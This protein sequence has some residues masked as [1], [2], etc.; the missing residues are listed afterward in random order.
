[1]S[2]EGA[3][4]GYAAG[5]AL[6]MAG[7]ASEPA[8]VIRN[9]TAVALAG[10]GTLETGVGLD[11]AEKAAFERIAATDPRFGKRLSEPP[12]A[13]QLRATAVKALAEG[14]PDVSVRD[15]E[16]DF[17]SFTA[18]A[19]ALDEAAKALDR[20]PVA[21]AAAGEDAGAA[22]VRLERELAAR[23]IREERARLDEERSLPRGASALVRG[24]EETW[25]AP[26]SPQAA[27][28]RDAWLT[29]RLDEIRDSLS[30]STLA[31][32][33]LLELD[34][35]LDPLERIAPPDVLPGAA[36]AIARL[37]VSL[38]AT[39]SGGTGGDDTRRARL[40]T[41]VRAHLGLPFEPK[42]IRARL[43][44]AERVTRALA[45]SAVTEA[46]ER[47]VAARAEEVTLAT[48][49]CEAGLFESRVRSMAPPPERGAICGLLRAI[50]DN[51]DGAAKAAALVALHDAAVVGLWALA[52][53]ADGALPD[54]AIASA[55]PFFGAQPDREA[56]LVRF[57]ETKPVAA[58][59]AG[60]AVELLL[61]SPKSAEA[62]PLEPRS[63][64]TAAATSK[65]WLT[66]GDAPLDVVE[67]ELF[68]PASAA[69]TAPARPAS[70]RP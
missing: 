5:V 24:I 20:V 29:A 33:P 4:L 30:G 48:G 59:G 56:R 45:R 21:S 42:E 50:R 66:F 67:R 25:S 6:T 60:L 57:A 18:R 16:L 12:S 55:H 3:T 53:H 9:V 34:D 54:R 64:A 11:D 68:S 65:R 43:E 19:R 14:D 28:E 1:M 26:S 62:S 70:P 69:P 51:T 17:F 2:W 27:S 49:K 58:I 40:E 7:C 15:G 46:E 52:I 61:R 37:R 8:P 13:D 38:E 39:P 63:A 47:V 10:H 44:E 41:G 22:K 35:A 31:R 23:V 36:K 32:G